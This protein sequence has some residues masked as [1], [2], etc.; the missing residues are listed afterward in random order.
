MPAIY[1]APEVILGMN[2]DSKVDIWGVGVMVSVY[3][4][5]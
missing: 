1:R 4:S 3:G 5:N 2:W